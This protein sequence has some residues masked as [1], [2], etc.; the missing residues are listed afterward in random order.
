MPPLSYNDAYLLLQSMLKKLR[1]DKGV[2]QAALA[3]LL[4]MPQSYVSKYEIG[5]RRLDLIETFEIC[6]VL[7]IDF[8]AF[9]KQLTK[10]IELDGGS[11]IA[12]PRD[13]PHGRRQK[14]R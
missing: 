8:V 2:T 11:G 3:E 14:A 1:R 10:R 5:E 9:V 4:G 6:R 13:K 12:G 7:G